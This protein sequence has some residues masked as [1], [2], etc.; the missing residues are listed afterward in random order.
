L[1]RIYTAD[2]INYCSA[3]NKGNEQ[4]QIVCLTGE[5]L[6]ITTIRDLIIETWLAKYGA[7]DVVEFVLA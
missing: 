2:K 7:Y 3:R 1:C 4:N 6:L 5:F